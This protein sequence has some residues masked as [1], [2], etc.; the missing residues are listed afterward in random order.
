[1]QRLRIIWRGWVMG[2]SWPLVELASIADVIDSRHKTPAYSDD[3]HPMVRVV[4]VRGGA[5]DLSSTKKVS[6]EVYAD[7]SKGRDPQ[8]GDLVISRVG[9]YG[10]IA[11]VA[12]KDKFCLGQNTALIVPTVDSR[13]LYY[14]LLS[15]QIKQQIETMVVGAVQKTI[16]L[17]SIK[18]LRVSLPDDS[19]QNAIAHI[20]GTLDDKIELNRQMNATLEAVAQ[21]LF[22]SWF[23]DFDPVID[24]A[25]AAGNPIPEPLQARAEARAAL[26]DQRKPLPEAIQ[27]QFPSSF[28]FDEELGWVPEGWAGGTLGSLISQRVERVQP[29]ELTQALPYVPIDCIASKSLFLDETK[30][31]NEAQSSLTKFYANDILFG[32]MRP[33]FHKVCIAP[34][35]GTTRTTAFVLYPHVKTDHSFAALQ[36]HQVRTIHYATAHSTG[37]TIPYAKWK[38]SLSEMQ[39]VM[40]PS[41][42]RASFN[43]LAGILLAKIPPKS[44][45]NEVLGKLRDALLPKLL[46]GQLR[47]PEAEKQVADVV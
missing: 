31:G 47:V 32:A 39:I 41:V 43:D 30:N 18:Q 3:G 21:A 5:L 7:F 33:Y 26:G 38:E 23:V 29:S 45:E 40:P 11:Y 37:T 19:T 14:Q 10:N 35:E 24:N 22:K 16:S 34:F 27:Q 4:D 9:S 1:M 8:V 44:S 12:T 17:K 20:L 6:D 36:L 13:F 25:L 2:D 46:S 28:V 15:P 42:I